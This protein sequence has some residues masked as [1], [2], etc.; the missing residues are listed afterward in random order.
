MKNEKNED[1][2][3]IEQNEATEPKQTDEEKETIE[4]TYRAMGR[5]SAAKI[6]E[7]ILKENIHEDNLISDIAD[8]DYTKG[9]QGK[10]H[11]QEIEGFGLFV[12]DLYIYGYLGREDIVYNPTG[13]ISCT[14]GA[15]GSAC[16][17]V[18][19]LRSL[20]RQTIGK[21]SNMPHINIMHTVEIGNQTNSSI[22]KTVAEIEK[23]TP[24]RCK[25]EERTLRQAFGVF[26]AKVDVSNIPI[27]ELQKY[28]PRTGKIAFCEWVLCLLC[29]L[30]PGLFRYNGQKRI[31]RLFTRRWKF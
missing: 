2:S 27:Q 9:H 10:T 7:H 4:A 20:V 28:I 29:R 11:L 26:V 6:A 16:C 3:N 1:L 13:G 14:Q 21:N 17:I 30:Y 15:N 22:L 23:K 31:N 24:I 8:V 19:M 12:D 25:W 18:E 5:R